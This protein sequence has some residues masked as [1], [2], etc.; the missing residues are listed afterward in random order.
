MISRKTVARTM[1]RMGLAGICPK[2]W[3]T[4]L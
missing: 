3:V 1:K 2:K 4:S